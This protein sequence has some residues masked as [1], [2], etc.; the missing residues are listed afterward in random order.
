MLW[1]QAVV[2]WICLY[3]PDVRQSSW[4]K[5]PGEKRCS[6]HGSCKIDRKRK[7][8]RKDKPFQVVLQG[9]GD[10]LLMTHLAVNT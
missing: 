10:H 7:F 3:K 9:N 1:F 6:L 8:Q 4:Q 5:D 2:G